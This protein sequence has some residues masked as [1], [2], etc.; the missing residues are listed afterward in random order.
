MKSK[1][2]TQYKSTRHAKYL[3]NYHFIWCPKYR[4]KILDRPEV[5][6]VVRKAIK[7]I[8]RQLECSIIALEIMPDHIHLSLSALP[9]YS[10]A[11]LVAR[12][13]GAS[14]SRVAAD[15]PELKKRKVWS[16]SYFCA[17]AGEV[18]TETIRKYIE[19]QWKRIK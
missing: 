5:I 6:E 2:N 19:T 12:I 3:I 1:K 13:K 4:R 10:P 15:F 11:Y 9:R 7:N 16:R 18:S 14:G 8:V 17:T